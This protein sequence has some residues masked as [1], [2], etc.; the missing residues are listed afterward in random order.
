MGNE[1]TGDDIS[2]TNS[3]NG[4]SKLFANEAKSVKAVRPVRSS[5]EKGNEFKTYEQILLQIP[6]M[7]YSFDYAIFFINFLIYSFAD[8][9]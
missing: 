7:F 1:S 6:L 8:I 4:A 2:S 9:R 5:L 3:F